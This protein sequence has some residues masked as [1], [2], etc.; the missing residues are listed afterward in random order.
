MKSIQDYKAY[1][2]TLTRIHKEI[3]TRTWNIFG[4][5]TRLASAELKVAAK[6]PAVIRGPH[7]LSA[8]IT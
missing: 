8:S 1:A 2:H 5:L 7:K 3:A 6:M 4:A